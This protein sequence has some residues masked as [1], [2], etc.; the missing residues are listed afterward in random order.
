MINLAD[1]L[2][3]L[4]LLPVAAVTA[5]GNGN[6]VDLQQYTGEIALILDCHNVAGVTPTMDVKIQ[7]SADNSSFADISP[8]V[9]FTQVTTTDF[10]QKIAVN[11]DEI[12]RYIRAVKTIGGTSSPQY[13]V[14]VKA[15]ALK[16]Y[17]A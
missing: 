2:Q 15:V 12:R 9:A 5:N 1:Q 4:D 16:K 17:P 3:L 14:S 8:A 10:A 13:L 11:K 7:D 6:G